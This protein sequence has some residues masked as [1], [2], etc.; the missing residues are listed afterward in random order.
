ML[1]NLWE[2][3]RGRVWE[4]KFLYR[5]NLF[6]LYYL[7]DTNT[8]HAK[9]KSRL[10]KYCILLQKTYTICWYEKKI[11][12][13]TWNIRFPVRTTYTIPSDIIATHT[14]VCRFTIA[15]HGNHFRCNNTMS[16]TFALASFIRNSVT[17]RFR[18]RF[19]FNTMKR[20]NGSCFNA[21]NI[22][23]QKYHERCRW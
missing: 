3:G 9:G 2:G 10:I 5:V 14:C 12:T 6:S 4:F 21:I 22:K 20:F 19:C 16:K 23:N 17:G 7:Y 8:L 11:L 1:P 18:S 15:D 13:C